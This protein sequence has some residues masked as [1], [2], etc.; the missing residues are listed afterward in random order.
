MASD[1]AF[2]FAIIFA[3]IGIKHNGSIER[4]IN[5]ANSAI[6]NG[7]EII[8]HQTHVVEDGICHYIQIID[9]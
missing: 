5:I 3:E 1:E 7:A 2:S 9:E 4:A 8:K 6:K